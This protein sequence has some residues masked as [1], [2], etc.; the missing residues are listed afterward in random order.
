MGRWTARTAAALW[1]GASV[2]AP[3][4]PALAKAKIAVPP[5]AAGGTVE[6][7]SV[8]DGETLELADGRRV[9]LVDIEVPMPG[10]GAGRGKAALAEEARRALSDLVSAGPVELRYAGNPIDRHGR[11]LADVVANG[12]WVQGALLRTGLAR[13]RS[14]AD[15]RA[16][17]PE[18][19]ALE[20]GARR[21]HRGIWAD[22]FYAVRRPEE[23]A[24]YAGSY[25]IVE[26][27]VVDAAA[28]DGAVFVNFGPDWHTAFSLRIGGAALKL[29]RVAGVD[30]LALEGKRLRVRGFIDG[31]TRPTIAVTHPEQIEQP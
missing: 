2:L 26:G 10:A 13:V 9:R 8:L 22:P 5:L 12:V 4:A 27:V 30:P 19:L 31:T 3:Q 17:V 11:V 20:R 25:Q 1:L 21:A 14:V 7:R 23:A 28:V 15:E 18:M 6:V 29:C 16:G 24:R